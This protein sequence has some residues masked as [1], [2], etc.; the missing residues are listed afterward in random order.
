MLDNTL[1][2]M[3]F[4]GGISL[5]AACMTGCLYSPAWAQFSGSGQPGAVTTVEQANRAGT[6]DRVSLTGSLKNE[7]RRAQ[8]LFRDATG[9][10]RVRIEHEFWRGRK[11]TSEDILNIRGR[12][13]SDVRGR[14][15]DVYYFKIIEEPQ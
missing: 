12:I 2:K 3:K 15:I 6:G 4:I 7:V 13:Q 10:I 5:A 11:V 1:M 9:E 14:F 8:Y